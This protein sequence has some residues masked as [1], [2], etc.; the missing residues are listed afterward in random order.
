M[1]LS[2]L[3][4]EQ[5]L[6]DIELLEAFMLFDPSKFPQFLEVTES[7]IMTMVRLIF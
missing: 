6:P 5:Q 2:K 7:L 3:N 4:I 1:D